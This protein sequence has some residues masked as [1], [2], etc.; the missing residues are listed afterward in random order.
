MKKV[1]VASA[2]LL[3]AGTAHAGVNLSGDARVSYVGMRDY[4]RV[5]S[6]TESDINGYDD[7]FESR[8]AINFDGKNEK[9]AGVKARLYFDNQG[10]NDPAPWNGYKAD[11]V[12]VDYAYVLVPL[13]EDFTIKAGRVDGDY[14]KFFSWYTR[15][16]R[17]LGIY[18]KGG[19]TLVPLV[20]VK[21]EFN[22]NSID[23]WNDND[24]MEYG[25]VGT[26]KM[27]NGWTLKGYARY[28]DDQRE[29]TTAGLDEEGNQLL[30]AHGDRSGF[31][32]D[33]FLNNEG[34]NCD[35]GFAAEIAFKEAGVQGST[36]DGVGGYIQL[37]K[38]MNA[39]TPAII[40]GMTTNGFVADNDFG[41][42]LFGGN[43][44][45]TVMDVGN[46]DGDLWFAGFVANYAVSEK[47]TLTGNLAYA[48]FDNN[49]A[50]GIADAIEISAAAQY[51]LTSG[52]S[53]TYSAG[54]LSPSYDGGNAGVMEDAYFGHMLQLEF[55]F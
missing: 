22:N 44:F 40:A 12:T 4:Q 42:L 50:G 46:S 14:S 2:A 55:E 49:K 33:I 19:L 11:S 52:A 1:L 24:F 8:I 35:F 18:K 29:W 47:F 10:F 32:G 21:S 30:K 7:Y 25:L 28:D 34:S 13:R 5:V 45:I 23:A 48:D 26:L 6:D 51:E 9:G 37:S 27:Q 43:R 54:Y 16:T 36:D 38:P 15:T 31:L 53:L 17:L 39:F 41:F 20:G 3:L